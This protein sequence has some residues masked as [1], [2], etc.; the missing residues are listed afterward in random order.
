MRTPIPRHRLDHG[1]YARLFTLLLVFTLAAATPAFAVPPAAAQ[2][3]THYSAVDFFDI[4]VCNWPDTPL[5]L[6]GLFSTTRFNDVARVELFAPDGHSMG[7]LNLDK[8]RTWQTAENKEK[9]AFMR[10]FDIPATA[11][12]GW[13]SATA[14][15][16]SGEIVQLRDYVII[17]TMPQ[18]THLNPPAEAEDIPL[19]QKL[20]WAP[21]PGARYY[22]VFIKDLWNGGGV[23]YSS[24]LL[25]KPELTVPAGVL[26][27]GGSYRWWVHARDVNVN[28][29]LGDFNHGSL[30]AEAAFT[31]AD[32]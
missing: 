18:A 4:H 3:D 12:S 1:G 32:Q 28:V 19:P 5:F 30:T 17:A 15:M 25:E 11:S 13:Y 6:L 7:A 10:H 29:L 31:V 27:P 14:T 2:Q 23:S 22:Q 21:V 16:K 24:D 9:H 26:E 20:T 8:F